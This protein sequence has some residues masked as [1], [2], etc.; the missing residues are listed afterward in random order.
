MVN[1]PGEDIDIC[2]QKQTQAV[3]IIQTQDITDIEFPNL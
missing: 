1:V 3:P 2:H